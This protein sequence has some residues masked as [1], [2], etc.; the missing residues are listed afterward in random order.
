[1]GSHPSQCASNHSLLMLLWDDSPFEI[2]DRPL[3]SVSSKPSKK[4][5]DPVEKSPSPPSKPVRSKCSSKQL[6]LCCPVKKNILTLKD[7]SCLFDFLFK[8]TV[9][10]KIN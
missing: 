8:C 4:A 9:L 1:M 10:K 7:C 5:M 2:C 3:P 6:L